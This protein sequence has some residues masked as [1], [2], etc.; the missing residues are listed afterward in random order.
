MTM[1]TILALLGI[2]ALAATGCVVDAMDGNPERS[3]R[4]SATS[5]LVGPS[6]GLRCET[7]ADCPGS[8][9]Y[10]NYSLGECQATPPMC[11]TDADCGDEDF[12]WSDGY[13]W[14][15]PELNCAP[16]ETVFEGREPM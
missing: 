4:E 15:L 9:P 14:F 16:G 6:C 10:C 3:A 13:C 11:A 7:S 5:D 12:C 1:R 8:E 2:L